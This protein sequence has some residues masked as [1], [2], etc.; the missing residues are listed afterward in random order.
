[1]K[2]ALALTQSS[3]EHRVELHYALGK[4]YEDRKLY[5]EAFEHY[6][7]GAKL[8]RAVTRYNPVALS[9][10]VA[11][12]KETFTPAFF[13]E[14]TGW[15]DAAQ[16]AIF[17]VGLPRSGSTLLEQVLASHSLVEGTSELADLGAIARDLQSTGSR[18][19]G[20]PYVKDLCGKDKEW[21]RQAGATY[22]R[23]TRVHR[24]LGRPYFINKM[25]NDFMHVGLI[26]LIL[27]NAKIIDARRHP[28]ACGWSYFKQHFAR[29]HEV[30]YDLADIGRYYADYVAL[31]THFDA[32]L[33]GR[34]HR[35]I[36]EDFVIDP[37][38]H[39]RS[40]LDY[41]GLPF[42]DSC[43]R[44]HETKR[45]VN[46]ASAEQ[47]RQPISAKGLSDWRPYEPWLSPLRDAL[48]PVLDAYPNAPS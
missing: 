32:V 4:A 9:D 19:A 5:S 2:Q 36:H 26:H 38:P 8:H 41:C 39:I 35:V 7:Q 33:P 27:P 1:M 43:L 40:L 11:L 29:G 23:T 12:C 13:A 48:G 16:D 14:R 20:Y 30:S 17:I 22:L 6:S 34:V 44:P 31:M 25:P 3:N 21:S 42:E 15:G 28:M 10:F 37:E 45:A 24:R 47:V 18:T 46:T